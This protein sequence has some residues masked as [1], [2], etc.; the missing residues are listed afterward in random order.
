[1][2]P[3]KTGMRT[4]KNMP[5]TFVGGVAKMLLG[6]GPTKET[7]SFLDVTPIHLEVRYIN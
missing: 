1:M 3:F 2:N 7:T 5:D 6:K 4:I